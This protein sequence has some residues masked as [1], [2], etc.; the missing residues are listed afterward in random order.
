MKKSLSVIVAAGLLGAGAIACVAD[1]RPTI[2]ERQYRQR[3][4]IENGVEDGDLTRREAR[5]LHHESQDIAQDRREALSDDGRIDRGERRHIR[6][7][8]RQLSDD[9]YRERHDA[10]ER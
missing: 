4:R 10:Q 2:A 3:E 9:I 5:R 8:Q 6:R 7:E 1:D